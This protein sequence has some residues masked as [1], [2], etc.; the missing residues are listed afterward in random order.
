MVTYLVKREKT[1]EGLMGHDTVRD[2]YTRGVIPHLVTKTVRV[3]R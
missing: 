3:V 1:R 2:Q